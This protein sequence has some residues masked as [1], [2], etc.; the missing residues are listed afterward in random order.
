MQAII[1][2]AGMGKRL[3]T[4]T[5]HNTKCMIEVN[6][7]KLIDR[8]VQ[9][10][11]D[12]GINKIVIVVGYQSKNLKDHVLHRWHDKDITFIENNNFEKSNNIYSLFLTKE[13]LLKDDTVLLESDL[14]FDKEI[15]VELVKDKRKNI[16]V[17]SK[18][19]DW[20]DG[21]VVDIDTTDNSIKSFILKNNQNNIDLYSMYKTVNIYKFSKEFLKNI[22]IPMLE[23]YCQS[24]NLNKYYEDALMVISNIMPNIFG[25]IKTDKYLWYEIDN[26]ND[27]RVAETIF[28]KEDRHEKYLSRYG[29]YWKFPELLDY[30]YLVNPYFPTK[31]MLKQI[32]DQSDILISNYP[33]GIN[34]INQMVSDIFDLD[35]EYITTGNGASELTSI[36]IKS[37][38][39]CKI[40]TFYPSFD[41]YW[42]KSS[43]YNC[44]VTQIN[45][46]N[47]DEKSMI[48][49]IVKISESC[50]YIILVNPENPTGN[51]ISIDS[52]KYILKEI[53]KNNA[54]LVLDESFVDFAGLGLSG[55]MMQNKILIENKNLIVIKSISKSFGVPGIRLGVIASS[56][57]E[58][59]KSIRLKEPLWNINAYAEKFLEILSNNMDSYWKA[60]DELVK[61]KSRFTKILRSTDIV[62]YDS[63]ANFLLIDLGIKG[64]GFEE[65]CLKNNIL[66]K[67]LFNKK[68]I[69]SKTIFRIAIK[70]KESNDYFYNTLKYFLERK[71]YE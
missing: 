31:T 68:G 22:Y 10:I 25:I 4:L 21:T 48:N 49:E 61:E 60:C 37:I 40:A 55:S 47:L 16:A 43:Q 42:K 6:G 27:Y 35:P 28:S 69:T 56:N 34:V 9:A 50:N 39:P 46:F 5:Q 57:K 44:D 23:I 14:I 54:K 70:D 24:P 29:G 58:L 2:A 67:N 18:Y 17:V 7:E 63:Y 64:L 41:E 38:S 32:S 11:L 36:L 15:L 66:I 59:I 26:I 19:Q 1:L 13:Y 52:I 20:M 33:S 51:M 3:K 8:S 12:S 45:S 71:K 53:D 30:C 62:V 65:F